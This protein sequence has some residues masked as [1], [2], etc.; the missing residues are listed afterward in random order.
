MVEA[1]SANRE[2]GT[3][4]RVASLRKLLAEITNNPLT[5]GQIKEKFGGLR[6]YV[7]GGLSPEHQGMVALAEALSYRICETCGAPGEPRT[8]IGRIRTL[9]DVCHRNRV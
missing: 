6:F 1:A 8:N 3:A 9:C 7:D 2:Y 4:P 5:V